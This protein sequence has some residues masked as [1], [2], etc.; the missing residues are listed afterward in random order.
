VWLWW[1]CATNS[2]SSCETCVPPSPAP[3]CAITSASSPTA[4]PSS[5]SALACVTSVISVGVLPTRSAALS[6]LTARSTTR[7]G[8]GGAA[9]AAA[10]SMNR[11]TPLFENDPDLPA[12]E[13]D[14]QPPCDPPES[15]GA[16][17]VEHRLANAILRVLEVIRGDP[18][19][20]D[21]LTVCVVSHAF[22]LAE[23]RE[24]AA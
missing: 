20:V 22:L 1:P 14:A 9:M 3:S 18:Q 5:G 11:R 24:Y 15:D 12:V 17:Q 21:E 2:L 10:A 6:P 8:A 19:S 7:P 23:S 16:P 13:R 4:L